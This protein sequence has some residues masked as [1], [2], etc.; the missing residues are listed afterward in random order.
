M[1]T[2]IGPLTVMPSF[3]GPFT[4][5]QSRSLFEAVGLDH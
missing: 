2:E 5:T 1:T 3:P 4:I